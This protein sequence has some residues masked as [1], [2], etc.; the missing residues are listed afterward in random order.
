MFLSQLLIT[1]PPDPP[2]KENAK[3]TQQPAIY[4]P[5]DGHNSPLGALIL[6]PSNM[7]RSATTNMR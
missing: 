1:V 6:T 5:A 3:G 7:Q 2:N 4:T